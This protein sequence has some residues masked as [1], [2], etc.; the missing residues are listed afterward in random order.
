M[1]RKLCCLPT[2]SLSV[3]ADQGPH[4]Y[5]LIARESGLTPRKLERLPAP[6]G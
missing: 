4:T 2:S 5:V 1:L 6:E 3:I